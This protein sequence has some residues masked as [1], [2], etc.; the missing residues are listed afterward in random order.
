[1]DDAVRP[2]QLF[3]QL[4]AW[5]RVERRLWSWFGLTGRLGEY[6]AGDEVTPATNR[7]SREPIFIMH[8]LNWLMCGP[9]PGA[10]I[11]IRAAKAGRPGSF[12]EWRRPSPVIPR[13]GL[14]YGAWPRSRTPM[15]LSLND[16]EYNAVQAAAAPIHPLQRDAFLKALAV[17]LE[18]HPVVGPG[19]VHRVAAELQKTFGVVAHSETLLAPAQRA[20]QMG[21]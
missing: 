4:L 21:R 1:M 7:Q 11:A 17:E 13:F 9:F 16:D 10:R 2:V 3:A 6:R 18:R 8:P 12:A 20:R 15:P 5:S 14:W 19:L